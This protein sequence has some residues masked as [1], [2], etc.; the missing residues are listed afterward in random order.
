MANNFFL[1]VV[2]IGVN[3]I[4][5]NGVPGGIRTPNLD[6]MKTRVLAVRVLT[7]LDAWAV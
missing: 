5:I 1:R 6:A 4:V 3:A 2:E 7:A